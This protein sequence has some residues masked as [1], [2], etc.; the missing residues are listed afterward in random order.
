MGIFNSFAD[1]AY[2]LK[3]GYETL[4]VN[5]VI[6]SLKPTARED[7]KTLA[8]E[9]ERVNGKSI[10][11]TINDHVVHL[12][13][14]SRRFRYELEHQEINYTRNR[15]QELKVV[16]SERKCIE[17]LLPRKMLIIMKNT[18]QTL[19]LH[20]HFTSSVDDRD[21]KTEETAMQGCQ[22]INSFF[23]KHTVFVIN[24]PSNSCHFKMGKKFLIKQ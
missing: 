23:P 17:T 12:I 3:D 1:E 18:H 2:S 14:H 15:E 10:L 4:K 13:T 19:G 24:I 6:G 5:C 21:R 11:A 16:D 7:F 9:T 8:T 22:Y 20:F